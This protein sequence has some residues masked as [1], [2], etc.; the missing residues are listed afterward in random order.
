MAH[1]NTDYLNNLIKR[2]K[3]YKSPNETQQLII[4]LGDKLHRTTEDDRKLEILLRAEKKADELLKARADIKR[5]LDAEKASIRKVETRKKIVWGAALNK[6]SENNPKMAEV[7][8]KL[9][10]DGYVSDRDKET[11]RADLAQ[12][13]R[14]DVKQ[15]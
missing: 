7:M 6:A 8:L 14:S 12:I 13:T 5:L 9:F 15:S 2:F 3:G 11:V 4:A 1:I 10:N